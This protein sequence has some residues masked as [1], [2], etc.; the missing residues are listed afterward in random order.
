VE[1]ERWYGPTPDY[2]AGALW[3]GGHDREDDVLDLELDDIHSQR[4]MKCRLGQRS[5][6]LR[7]RSFHRPPCRRYANNASS[8]ALEGHVL[9][10]A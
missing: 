1:F 8:G 5:R 4:R 9:Q 6:L 3:S 10:D 7:D 2:V